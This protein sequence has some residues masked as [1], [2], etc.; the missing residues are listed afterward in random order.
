MPAQPGAERIRDRDSRGTPPR[1]LEEIAGYLNRHV[2]TIRRWEKHEGL[3]VIGSGMRSSARFTPTPEN[4]TPGSRAGGKR[5]DLGA[6]TDRRLR[7]HP[8][9]FRLLRHWLAVLTRATQLHRARRRDRA[10]SIELEPCVS[11]T[12]ANRRGHRRTGARGRPD[13]CM[14]FALSVAREATVLV[15][16]AGQGGARRY[17]PWVTILQWIIRTTPSQDCAVHLAGIEVRPT[18]GAPRP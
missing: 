16:R 14:E 18:T 4:W 13:W 1:V 7:N 2:T 12:A 10:F 3:P 11:R 8:S 9:A 15:G 6:A 17:A 5:S